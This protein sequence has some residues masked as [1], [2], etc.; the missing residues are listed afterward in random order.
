MWQSFI[1]KVKAFTVFS[2][3]FSKEVCHKDRLLSFFKT[4]NMSLL[5]CPFVAAC[6]PGQWGPNCM[7]TCNCHNGA[8]CS[9]YDG[10][11]KCLPGWSG[12]YCTQRQSGLHVHNTTDLRIIFTSFTKNVIITII[13]N[14]VLLKMSNTCIFRFVKEPKYRCFKALTVCD[15]SCRP[16]RLSTKF[17]REGLFSELSVQERS[18]LWPHLWTVHLSHWLHRTT[19]WTEYVRLDYFLLWSP[20]SL[21]FF[22]SVSSLLQFAPSTLQ[23]WLSLI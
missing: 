4:N 2:L 15:V 18:W 10:E 16:C 21:F 22:L 23:T 17:L 20:W 9:A 1:L 5:F 3:A 7:H 11:C 8:Y 12:L 19:L 6:P 13:I 14:K